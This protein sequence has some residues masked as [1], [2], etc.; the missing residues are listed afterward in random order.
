MR[1]EQFIP[2]DS[3]FAQV[4]LNYKRAQTLITNVAYRIKLSFFLQSAKYVLNSQNVPLFIII[5]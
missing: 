5:N 4:G 2:V 1:N 3:G